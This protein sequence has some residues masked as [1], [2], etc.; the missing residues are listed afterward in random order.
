MENTQAQ[1]PLS[2]YFRQPAIYMNLPSGGKFWEENSLDLPVNGQIPVY[3]MTA[4]DEVTLRTPDALLNGS[5]VVDVIQS[6]CPN[7]KNAW[8]MPSV[9]VD[10][11]LIAIRIASY[12]AQMDIDTV[13]PKCQEENNH[14]L[15]LSGILSSISCPD[16]SH[17]VEVNNLKIKI[18]PQEFF[19]IN[20]KNNLAF[21][22]QRL[23]EAVSKNDL[24]NEEQTQ[25]INE[26]MKN[27]LKI[28]IDTI[29]EST[30]SIELDDG[31][32]VAN[33]A[34]ITDFFNNADGIVIRTIQKHLGEI[35]KSASIKDRE[36]KCLSCSTEYKVPL[37]FDYA[38]F[39][40]Q[41]S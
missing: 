24:S 29:A 21:E 3:P 18:K 12:G 35:N 2:K 22:E 10:A 33:P 4:R 8:K 34:F 9:D 16:Y 39:F 36:I 14:G 5:S 15:D 20:K 7:I 32:I 1:N 40:V 37:E 23:L 30:D 19:S 26:S 38:N 41:G 28:S 25:K 31:T 11:V 6:C 27:L 17:K 13:C